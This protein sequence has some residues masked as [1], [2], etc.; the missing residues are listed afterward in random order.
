MDTTVFKQAVARATPTSVGLRRVLGSRSL[1]NAEAK[2][3]ASLQNYANDLLTPATAPTKTPAK[4]AQLRVFPNLDIQIR[5]QPFPGAGDVA[6]NTATAMRVGTTIVELAGDRSGNLLLWIDRKPVPLAS[7]A[8][9]GG[10]TLSVSEGRFATVTWPD[11]TQATVYSATTVAIAHQTATC[12]VSSTIYVDVNVPHSQFGHLTGLLGDTGGSP[13]GDLVGGNG[14]HYSLDELA[15]PSDSVQ[16]YDALYHGFGQS[17][18]ISQQGSLFVYPK[19]VGTR[20]YTDLA[21]PSEALTI[22]SLTPKKVSGAVRACKAAGIT[23]RNLLADCVFDVG[24][25]GATCF[26]GDDAHVLPAESP[27]QPAVAVD[28]SGTAY[29]VWLQPGSTKL[30]FCKLPAGSTKCSPVSLQV[31][32]PSL[33]QFFDP[34]TVL[35]EGGRIYVFEYV[36]STNNGEITGINDYVSSNGGTSFSWQ[37][38]AVGFVPGGDGTAG[39][40]VPLP[41]GRFGAGYVLPGANPGFQVNSLTAPPTSRRRPRPRTRP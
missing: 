24:V 9:A 36:G 17:W 3:A 15:F 6:V 20:N 37:T 28:A 5:Q 25:T 11:G 21:F 29:T 39:P 40:I 18:R 7:Q 1:T 2:A 35:V 4:Q 8:L 10:G 27:S 22:R 23:N 31:P 34:P 38:H 16:N 13:F 32:G 14:V 30:D 33:D 26:A 41:G 19:G 12:N